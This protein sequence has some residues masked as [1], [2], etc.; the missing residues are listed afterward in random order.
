[1][2]ARPDRR[3]KPIAGA[4]AIALVIAGAVGVAGIAGL[5]GIGC[6]SSSTG[7]TEASD[8]LPLAVGNTWIYAD[9]DG[10][11]DTAE[12]V[13]TV[14]ADGRTYFDVT[15]IGG[16]FG[17]RKFRVSDDG[18]FIYIADIVD[19]L[20][21]SLG[22]ALVEQFGNA[23]LA[24]ISA[25]ADTE[26][27]LLSYPLKSGDEWEVGDMS[28]NAT[29]LVQSAPGTADIEVTI[30]AKAGD[31]ADITGPAGS[32]EALPVVWSIRAAGTAVVGVPLTFDEQLAAGTF[33][34]VREV[35]LAATDFGDGATSLVEF[36]LQ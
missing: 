32:F 36:D 10:L 12:V 11:K 26:W 14:V 3:R 2:K 29:I 30:T 28:V 19:P 20:A 35:G 4:L 6:S 18:V 21:Y 31:V 1:M 33:Q 27:T 23:Q 9:T 17:F 25:V 15:N 22:S 5:A 13:G 8:Y 24:S 7:P 16:D 34:F